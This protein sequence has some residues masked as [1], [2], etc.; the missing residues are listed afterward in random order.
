MV[1]IVVVV[2]DIVAVD[3]VAVVVVVVVVAAVVVAVVVVQCCLSLPQ[4]EGLVVA[5]V[6]GWG[7]RHGLKQ[8]HA[9]PAKSPVQVHH[10][11]HPLQYHTRW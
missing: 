11:N 8:R 3:T 5:Q 4:E 9:L 6:E 7:Q 2:V 1:A 10:Q